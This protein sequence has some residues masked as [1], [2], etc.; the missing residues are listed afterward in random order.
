MRKAIL[1]GIL[2]AIS[3]GALA[4]TAITNITLRGVLKDDK[5]QPVAKTVVAVR[6]DAFSE[7]KPDG[8]FAIALTNQVVP[9]QTITLLVRKDRWIIN[10]PVDGKWNVPSARFFAEQSLPVT[11]VPY[12]SLA[13]LSPARLNEQILRI[14][15]ELTRK[16]SEA[17]QQN[18]NLAARD[19]ENKAEIAAL[20]AQVMSDLLRQWEKDYGL[21]VAKMEEVI[22]QYAGKNNPDD[23]DY[24]KGMKEFFNSNYGAAAILLSKSGEAAA[25]DAKQLREDAALK[26]YKAFQS[27]KGAGDAFYFDSQYEKA[28]SAYDLAANFINSKDRPEEWASLENDRGLAREEFGTRTEP[29]AAK[30]LLADSIQH[31]RQVLTVYTREQIPQNWAGTQ[32]NLGNALSNQAERTE[33]AEATHLF[34]EAVQAF[35]QVLTIYTNEKLW[36]ATQNNLGVA[37]QNQAEWAEAADAARLLAQAVQAFRYAL[38]IYTHKQMPQAW[39]IMQ[40]NLGNVLRNQA[41]RAETADAARLFAEAAQAFRQALTVRTREQMPQ[42]WAATQNN[43]GVT[44]QNQAERAEGADAARLFAEAVQAYRQA[45]T[46]YTREELPQDWAMTQNNLGAALRAQAEQVGEE[47]GTK[48]LREAVAAF[49]LALQVRQRETLPQGWFQTQNNLAEAYYLFEDWEKAGL[50]YANVLSL[51]PNYVKGLERLSGIYHER[52]FRLTEAFALNERRVK[53]NPDNL[54]AQSDWA[55]THFTTARFAEAETRLATL[56]ASPKLSA[57]TQTALRALAIANALALGKAAS[58]N[59]KLAA[60]IAAVAQQPADF[61]VGW[62]FN[63]TLH[64][65]G[66]HESL[67][68]RRDWLRQLIAALQAD[69]RDAIVSALRDVQKQFK[70]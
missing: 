61:R 34:A 24:T 35:R 44:L 3:H 13:L 22:R 4:Q 33:G 59:D 70:P 20:K 68:A 21:T 56:L 42:Q 9:G 38:T 23:D 27:Y 11:I 28:I 6:G 62:S 16:L 7:T 39:A 29:V 48:L 36:A 57:S 2:F 31:Y 32:N 63:G 41:E 58:V 51:R 46:V 60:L 14:K 52:L 43:L 1:L 69:N 26:E 47:A 18:R 49:E 66:T 40:N 30:R 37:L 64:F 12:G 15:D 25:K 55:E 45:L 50:A 54:S 65:I 53:L 19:A 67:A 17:R 8:Q 10:D 5:G